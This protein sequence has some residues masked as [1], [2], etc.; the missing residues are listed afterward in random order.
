MQTLTEVLNIGAD[1]AKD[2]VVVACSEGSFTT[3]PLANKRAALLVFLK[4]L[5]AGSRIGMESTGIYHELFANL[6]HQLGFIV[7][8]LVWL[9]WCNRLS[10]VIVKK[11][12]WRGQRPHL[13]LTDS[14]RIPPPT[15]PSVD[16]ESS[17]YDRRFDRKLTP[18]CSTPVFFILIMGGTSC[19]L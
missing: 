8:V 7:F 4:G 16:E 17:G 5:P 11:P 6:A 1:V 2:E 14:E 13:L 19:K 3:R 12:G 15:P 18:V 10:S 9:G